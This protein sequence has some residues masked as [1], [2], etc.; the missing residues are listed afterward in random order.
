MS[1]RQFR[2]VIVGGGI[3]GLTLANMLEKFDIDYIVLEGRDDVAPHEGACIGIS[4]NG[5]FILDQLGLYET[6]SAACLA[7]AGG[8]I[9]HR[10]E[11]G[12]SRVACEDAWAHVEARYVERSPLRRRGVLLANLRD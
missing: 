9:Q 8:G 11:D 4:P 2:V 6:V 3:A 7:G 1:K 5:L 12:T 10:D